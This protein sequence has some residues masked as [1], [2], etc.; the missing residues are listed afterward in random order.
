MQRCRDKVHTYHYIVYK[1]KN[2]CL[3]FTE[4]VLT[5]IEDAFGGMSNVDGALALT[6]WSAGRKDA[7]GSI[8][9]SAIPHTGV[10]NFPDDR[11]FSFFYYPD[12]AVIYWG[13]DKGSTDK[14][15]EGVKNRKLATPKHEL[16]FT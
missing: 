7:T 16:I 13:A 6:N 4:V 1:N 11:A 2:I 5:P 12:E 9:T 10:F 14:F 8:D 3:F 15:W